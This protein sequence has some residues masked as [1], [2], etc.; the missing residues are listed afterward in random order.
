[1]LIRD[2]EQVKDSIVD[3][4]YSLGFTGK[5]I[6]EPGIEARELVKDRLILIASPGFVI[7][8]KKEKKQEFPLVEP[9]ACLKLPFVLREPGSATRMLFEDSIQREIP[10]GR[11][12]TVAYLE[13]QEA[14]KEAVKTGLGVTVISQRAVQGELEAGFLK[15]YLIN[16]LN[17]YRS[18]YLIWRENRFLA[19]LTQLFLNFTLDYFSEPEGKNN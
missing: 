15:G 1:V 5:P 11:L 7:P 17:L 4:T 2:T 8:C 6:K 14:I 9:A 19:P 3:F 10:G 16:R 18:F 12:K 13:S